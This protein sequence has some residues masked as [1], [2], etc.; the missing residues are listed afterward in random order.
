MQKSD[1]SERPLRSQENAPLRSRGRLLSR[2]TLSLNP[3]LQSEDA[4]QY[5]VKGTSIGLDLDTRNVCYVRSKN[6]T[7]LKG[8]DQI[9]EE[10]CTLWTRRYGCDQL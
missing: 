6:V 1:G 2:E 9:L 5:S 8:F 7:T 3:A 4:I 10:A